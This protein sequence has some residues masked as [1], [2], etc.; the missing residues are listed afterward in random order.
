MIDA[1]VP[2]E[3]ALGEVALQAR[4][5]R[6]ILIFLAE[7]RAEPRWIDVCQVPAREGIYGVEDAGVR[8]A[9]VEVG[10]ALPL[11]VGSEGIGCDDRAEFIGCVER[12]TG[13]I[14][15]RLTPVLDRVGYV[16]V[17]VVQ[18]KLDRVRTLT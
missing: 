6:D 14:A 5:Q 3:P 12:K 10:D 4:C 16:E 18:L 8:I 9:P 15:S 7:A 1:E 17:R 13:R 2:C 11:I